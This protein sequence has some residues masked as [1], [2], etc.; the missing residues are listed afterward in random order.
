VIFE[1]ETVTIKELKEDMVYSLDKALTEGFSEQIDRH[2]IQN[3]IDDLTK[4]EQSHNKDYAVQPKASLK[5]PSLEELTEE[6]TKTG[7]L[8]KGYEDNLFEENKRYGVEVVLAV[9]KRLG[10]FA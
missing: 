1:E 10:N 5:L 3:W 2:V 7:W 9:I 6:L 4:I 8:F